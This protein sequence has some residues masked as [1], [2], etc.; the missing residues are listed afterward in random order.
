MAAVVEQIQD[1][2]QG[3]AA[4]YQP[5]FYGVDD[6]GDDDDSSYGDHSSES[7]ESSVSRC[8]SE[9]SLEGQ[10]ELED[11]EA[12][13]SQIGGCC[14]FPGRTRRKK[15]QADRNKIA[16]ATSRAGPAIGERTPL[17]LDD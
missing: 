14:C 11:A 2:P 6:A 9:E 15:R 4:K 7:S 12:N 10:R 1:G 13:P 16:A 17:L 5:L 3:H 8:S